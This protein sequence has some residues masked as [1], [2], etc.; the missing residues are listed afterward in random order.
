M[1]AKRI[2]L[3]V[4]ALAAV[5]GGAWYYKSGEADP[6]AAPAQP[7]DAAAGARGGRG[8]RSGLAMTVE[9]ASVS[10][11]EISEAV[12]VVGNL[13]GEATVDVVPRLA[14]RLEA[15]HV[16]LGDRISKGQQVAKMDD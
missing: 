8:G 1:Q 9:A 2:V 7:A 16:K 12:T 5:G 4:V 14:G 15:V 11:H 13:I 6:Q 3:I 10:K